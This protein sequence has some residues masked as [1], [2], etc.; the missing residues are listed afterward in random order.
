MVVTDGSYWFL[1]VEDW[2]TVDN[3][4]QQLVAMDVYSLGA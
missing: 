3:D 4:E 2:L 1:M